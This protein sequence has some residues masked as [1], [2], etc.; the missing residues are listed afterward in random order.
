[1]NE[2]SAWENGVRFEVK[3]QPRSSRNQWSGLSDGAFKI[4]LTA[5]PVD[6]E[7]NQALIEFLARSLGVSKR[8]VEILRGETSKLKL[9]GIHNLTLDDAI[10]LL[11][12]D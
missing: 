9:I 5:P 3:V 8:D 11:P 12:R 7:A 6:G 1:M 4:K 10:K 2:I